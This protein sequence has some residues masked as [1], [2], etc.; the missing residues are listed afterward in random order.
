MS[1]WV[2]H[3]FVRPDTGSPLDT[4]AWLPRRW[5][6]VRKLFEARLWAKLAYTLARRR[7]R[8]A[9]ARRR[10]RRRARPRHDA[11]RAL[12]HRACPAGWEHHPGGRAARHLPTGAVRRARQRRRD[13]PRRPPRPDRRAGRTPLAALDGGHP[14]VAVLGQATL[15]LTGSAG[16]SVRPRRPA[17]SS[18]RRP[19]SS[20]SRAVPFG[21]RV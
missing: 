2:C 10:P 14:V 9:E 15:A 20:A 17:N 4:T 21:T 5:S 12:L 13:P 1:R 3:T 18:S 16:A 11:P 6:G 8:S 19:P 7:S